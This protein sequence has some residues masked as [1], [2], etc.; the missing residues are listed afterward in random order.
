MRIRA[1]RACDAEALAGIVNHYIR[2]TTIS[3]TETSKSAGD[4]AQVVATRDE[5]GHGILVAEGADGLLGYASYGPFRAGM[6]YRET[7]EHTVLLRFGAEGRGVGRALMTALEAHAVT[8]G[9]HSLIG[10]ISAENVGGI[11]F[12]RRIGF[13]EVGRVTQA[14][15]KFGRRIDLVLMQKLLSSGGLTP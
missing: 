8:G 14:G 13:S 7:L 6:G 5:A 2:E 12:H 1:A 10:G 4:M 11:A 3:F 15:L 9:M